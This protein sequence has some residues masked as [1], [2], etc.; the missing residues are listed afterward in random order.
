[1]GGAHDQVV[2]EETLRR[3]QGG[4]LTVV[5]ASVAALAE[6][7]Q[8]ESV[9]VLEALVRGYVSARLWPEALPYLS[10]L[11][12]RQPAHGR[13][14]LWRAQTDEGREHFEEAREDYRQAVDL[15]PESSEARLGLANTLA[16]LGRTREAAAQYE[17]L[18]RR[19]PGNAAVVLGLA[20]C[21][22]DLHEL[23]E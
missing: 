19:Q 14:Y 22:H 8:P 4:D 12:Q 10:A 11:L 21:R 2:L 20:R 1:L 5:D 13:A 17:E 6:S 18:R 23:A 3:A 7:D 16:R 15:I 9:L